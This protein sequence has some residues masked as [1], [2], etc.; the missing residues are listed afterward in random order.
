[1][2][3]KTV[4]LPAGLNVTLDGMITLK[5]YKVASAA[6]AAG[7]VDGVLAAFKPLFKDWGGKGKPPTKT[8][9]DNLQVDQYFALVAAAREYLVERAQGKVQA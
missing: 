4:V 3:G 7:D 6:D 8:D 1:M 9:F 5:A 2:T